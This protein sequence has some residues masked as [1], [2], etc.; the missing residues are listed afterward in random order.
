MSLFIL[1]VE[2]RFLLTFYVTFGTLD[3]SYYRALTAH[4]QSMYSTVISYLYGA[5]KFNHKIPEIV[6]SSEISDTLS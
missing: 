1:S 2:E 6:N 3:L 5:V 4:F